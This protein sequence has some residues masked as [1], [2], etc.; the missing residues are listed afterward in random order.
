MPHLYLYPRRHATRLYV[1][2]VHA[3]RLPESEPLTNRDRAIIRARHVDRDR[4]LR[5]AGRLGPNS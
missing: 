1:C 5:A 4:A 3:A 2:E